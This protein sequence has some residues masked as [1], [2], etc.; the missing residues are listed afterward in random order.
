MLIFHLTWNKLSTNI[1]R[2]FNFKVSQ[3]QPI[4]LQLFFKKKYYDKHFLAASYLCFT[5]QNI[6]KEKYSSNGIKIKDNKTEDMV[7]KVSRIF[8][9]CNYKEIVSDAADFSFPFGCL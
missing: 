3:P 7:V 4:Q 8:T 6:R 9:I 1:I 5:Q 2:N